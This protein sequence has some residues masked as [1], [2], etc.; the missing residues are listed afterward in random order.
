M[1]Q[2]QDLQTLLEDLVGPNVKVYF[3][4]PS[5]I[6]LT[7]PCVVYSRDASD[8]I[9]S[10]DTPYRIVKRYQVTVI[11]RNPDSEIPAKIEKLRY[12]SFVRYFATDNL[13]HDVF[14]LY[15]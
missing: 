3:Q 15:F 14:S 11:D 2:R 10:D 5:S 9:F 1:G 4:P 13:N 6:T 12:C 8:T 7:Y